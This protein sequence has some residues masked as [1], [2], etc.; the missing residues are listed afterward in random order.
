MGRKRN[1]ELASLPEGA[2]RATAAALR[3]LG[4]SFGAIGRHLGISRQAAWR[5][6]NAG[7]YRPAP[8]SCPASSLYRDVVTLMYSACPPASRRRLADR[9]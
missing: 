7:L 5:P 3:S 8:G 1:P 4:L 2:Q 9:S 6:R